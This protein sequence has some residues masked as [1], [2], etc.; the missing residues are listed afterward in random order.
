MWRRRSYLSL[1]IVSSLSLCLGCGVSTDDNP[2]EK[3]DQRSQSLEHESEQADSEKNSGTYFDCHRDKFPCL[4]RN[5]PEE[6]QK[7]KIGINAEV[8]RRLDEEEQDRG[9]ILEWLEKHPDVVRASLTSKP[10]GL[11]FRVRGATPS[12]FLTPSHFAQPP[13]LDKTDTDQQNT[14]SNSGSNG[15][16]TKKPDKPSEKTKP[17]SKF[18]GSG[19]GKKALVMDAYIDQWVF[20]QK[21]QWQADYTAYN[22]V[23]SWTESQLVQPG[24]TGYDGMRAPA[25]DSVKVKHFANWYKYAFVYVR[26]HGGAGAV[27]NCQSCS[28]EF[29][30]LSGDKYYF[31]DQTPEDVNGDGNATKWEAAWQTCYDKKA[32]FKQNVDSILSASAKENILEG[33]Q[34]PDGDEYDSVGNYFAQEADREALDCI[35]MDVDVAWMEGQTN[36]HTVISVRQE[37]LELAYKQSLED[38]LIYIGACSSMSK[39]DSKSRGGKAYAKELI[40]KTQQEALDSGSIVFGYTDTAW[41]DGMT[42]IETDLFKWLIVHGNDLRPTLSHTCGGPVPAPHENYAS[43]CP[44]GTTTEVRVSD[45]QKNEFVNQCSLLPSSAS[46]ATFVS[47]RYDEKW[48]T[49][50]QRKCVNCKSNKNRK[51]RFCDMNDS[52]YSEVYTGCDTDDGVFCS[53]QVSEIGYM[54]ELATWP[55]W[56]QSSI[57]DKSLY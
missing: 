20:E 8:S 21:G 46:S 1:L 56:S 35:S 34:S 15:P 25:A 47:G 24:S 43:Q 52:E 38:K 36:P 11:I 17:T 30:L 51:C 26:T 13:E 33:T 9:E 54:W 48:A 5:V 44:R 6:A 45:Q 7:R 53:T 19:N 37:F 50:E 23:A 42:S 40:G 55:N 32:D 28:E 27:T 31:S 41:T 29:G 49:C 22:E 14:T 2:S 18:G 16:E 39:A 3:L 10:D 4:D 12:K 57:P